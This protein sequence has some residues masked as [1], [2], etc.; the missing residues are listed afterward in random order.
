MLECD[1]LTSEFTLVNN[2]D[3]TSHAL[4]RIARGTG[5][6]IHRDC[7]LNVIRVVKCC[8]YSEVFS[9]VKCCYNNESNLAYQHVYASYNREIKT[10][11]VFSKTVSWVFNMGEKSEG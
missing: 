11:K 2:M 9:R 7:Y 4:Q 5:T 6:I 1:N 10:F 8:S 3:E